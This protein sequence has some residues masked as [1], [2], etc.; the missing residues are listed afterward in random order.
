MFQVEDT[1]LYGANGICKIAR[2]AE[3]SFGGASARYYW[4]QPVSNQS[5]TI[6]VPVDN[7]ALTAK[8][9][10]VLSAEEIQQI[11][12]TLAQA[13]PLWY[14]AETERR[15]KYR[16]VIADGDCVQLG[17]M[18]KALYLHQQ[19]QL[20]SGKKLHQSDERLFKDAERVMYEEFA[21]VLHIKPEEVLH[22]IAEQI[23][24][25]A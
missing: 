2:I 1:V 16:Q 24:Q 12:E 6:Y 13:E 25:T 7:T 5:T 9:R 4:L 22:Y 14:E 17:R 21:L 18:I 10:R 3:T 11:I 19:K 15:E 20:A 8:M 23:E